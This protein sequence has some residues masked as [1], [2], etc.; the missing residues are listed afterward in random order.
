MTKAKIKHTRAWASLTAIAKGVSGRFLARGRVV[1]SVLVGLV[2][3]VDTPFVIQSVQN[4]IR[5]HV[6][7]TFCYICYNK[8][9]YCY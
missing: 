4:V 6:V 8:K 7:Y 3:V 2:V 9:T 1:T 5:Y